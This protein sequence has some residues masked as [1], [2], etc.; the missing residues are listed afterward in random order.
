MLCMLKV[1]KHCLSNFKT[2]KRQDSK[3]YH[4]VES[5][6]RERLYILDIVCFTKER[7]IDKSY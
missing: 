6:K 7:W 2:L 4:E 1:I 5:I 3:I